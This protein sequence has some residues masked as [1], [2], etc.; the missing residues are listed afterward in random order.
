MCNYKTLNA[1]QYGYVVQCNGCNHIEV[2]FATVILSL[3]EDQFY[4][5]IDTADSLYCQH[6]LHP[7]RDQKVIKLA[8]DARTVTMALSV[9]ELKDF[10]NLLIAGRNKLQ[11]RQLFVFNDN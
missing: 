9:N 2:A 1:N 5:L 6:N 4:G 11:Y 8:T 3:T 7:F 10:L